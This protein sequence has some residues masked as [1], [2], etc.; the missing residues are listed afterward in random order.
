[1]R[2]QPRSQ[3]RSQPRNHRV[4][5]RVEHIHEGRP[6]DLGQDFFLE[7]ILKP[8]MKTVTARSQTEKIIHN[9]HYLTRNLCASS[10]WLTRS[11]LRASAFASVSAARRCRCSRFFFCLDRFKI[12]SILG[13]YSAILVPLSDKI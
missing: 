5:H 2:S 11:E 10:K 13:Y 7:Q 4:L 3:L 6:D 9:G 1:M 12:L 8:D